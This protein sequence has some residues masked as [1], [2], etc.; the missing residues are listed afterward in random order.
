MKTLLPFLCLALGACATTGKQATPDE[1]MAAFMRA[2]TPGEEHRRLDVFVGDWD[3]AITYWMDPAAPPSQMSGR[4]TSEWILDGHYLDQR[5]SGEM[6]GMPFDGRGTFGYD[7][8]GQHY[9][10]TW[11]D[12]M[13]TYITV[14]RGLVSPD[15]RVFRLQTIGTDP[16]TGKPS[17]GR[18]EIVVEGPDRHTMAI[19]EDRGGELVKTMDMVYTRRK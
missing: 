19:F 12:S 8:A 1:M 17:E 2:G 3:V 14:T 11:I 6:E 4:M 7:I 10:G 9:F 15:G 18:E 5:F 16:V 13:S